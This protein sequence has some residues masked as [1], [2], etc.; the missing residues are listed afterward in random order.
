MF[1]PGHFRRKTSRL[2]SY[3]ALFECNMYFG[4][5]A[6]DLGSFPLDYPTYLVQ[7]DSLSIGNMAFEFDRLW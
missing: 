4:T 2:V 3:Y 5:L 6:G 7:S 1:C